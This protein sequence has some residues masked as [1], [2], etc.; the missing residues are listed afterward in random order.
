MRGHV[1]RISRVVLLAA[2]GLLVTYAPLQAQPVQPLGFKWWQDEMAQRKIGLSTDQSKR[3]EE[4]FQAALPELR[5]AKKQLDAVEK[6]LSRLVDSPDAALIQQ[7][8]RVEAARADLNKARTL[9][10]LRIRRILTADQRVRLEALH[11]GRAREHSG[12]DNRH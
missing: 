10:L 9:M 3:I 8:D 11:Q 12:P 5:R 2:A 4:V 1:S 6:D 7:V